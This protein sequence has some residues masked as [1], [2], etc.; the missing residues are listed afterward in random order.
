MLAP[1]RRSC[2]RVPPTA[3]AGSNPSLVLVLD[4][5]C[6]ERLRTPVVEMTMWWVLA[7]VI[8]MPFVAV[9]L[10]TARSTRVE[11]LSE[12]KR[13]CASFCSSAC[14]AG[15]TTAGVGED[16]G[17]ARGAAGASTAS[18][19]GAAQPAPSATRS[20]TQILFTVGPLNSIL[21]ATTRAKN[22]G[23]VAPADG[24]F[25]SLAKA[26]VSGQTTSP[27]K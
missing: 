7:A 19:V 6:G 1:I 20:S 9:V 18:A 16:T 15:G 25:L 21:I 24:A 10:G 8:E 2:A 4:S 13:I 12:L 5:S 11:K 3:S 27:E 22:T 17:C 14:S 23:G 26:L